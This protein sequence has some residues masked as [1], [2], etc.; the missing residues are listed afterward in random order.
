MRKAI[1]IKELP[2][3]PNENW[4]DTRNMLVKHVAKVYNKEFKHAYGM[5]ERVHR[6]GRNG[7]RDKKNKRD[8]YALCYGWYDSKDLV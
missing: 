1:V 3:K 7:F 8:I 5:F 2:E 4:A 6:I